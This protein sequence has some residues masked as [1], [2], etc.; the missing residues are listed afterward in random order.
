M[1]SAILTN[2]DGWK[3]SAVRSDPAV[4]AVEFYP[5]MRD[6]NAGGQNQRAG[7]NRPGELFE[8]RIIKNRHHRTRNGTERD[9][10]QL[11]LEQVRA[12]FGVRVRVDKPRARAVDHHQPQRQQGGDTKRQ[13]CDGD[14]HFI[15]SNASRCL[16]GGYCPFGVA[17]G[18]GATGAAAGAGAAAMGGSGVTGI[19]EAPAFAGIFS[20]WPTLILVVDRLFSV[21]IAL[22]VVPC[23]LR[24]L[25]QRV[26]GFDDV[27]FLAASTGCAG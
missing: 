16:I 7:E 4:R 19:A 10:D 5:E 24:N 26:A 13:S 12:D 6:E 21:S 3:V 20:F 27:N 8:Q 1:M 11:H 23:A 17:A 15:F 9:P 2:S 18:A 22:T 25:R 14:F